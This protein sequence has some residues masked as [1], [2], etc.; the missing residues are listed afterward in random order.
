M[1]C[2]E[3]NISGEANSQLATQ[4]ISRLLRK[5]MVHYHLH[6]SPELVRILS[7]INSIQTSL[8]ILLGSILILSSHLLLCLSSGIFSLD[9]LNCVFL[10]VK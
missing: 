2:M 8:P 7:H 3:Q 1:N 5:R 6:K 9:F 4:E 10:I